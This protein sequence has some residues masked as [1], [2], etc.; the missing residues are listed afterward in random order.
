VP[1][2]EPKKSKSAAKQVS[3]RGG[4]PSHP[5][6]PKARRRP[7]TGPGAAVTAQTT[8]SAGASTTDELPVEPDAPES[9]VPDVLVGTAPVVPTPGIVAGGIRSGLSIRSVLMIMLI[10]VSIASSVV[11]GAIGYVN[12]RASLNDAAF[13]RLTE[14]RD[15][16]AREV[17]ALFDSVKSSLMINSRGQSVTAATTAFSAAFADLETA[18]LTAAEN[19]TVDGYYSSTFAPALAK[20]TGETVDASSFDPTDPAA[21]YLTLNYVAQ[22]TDAAAALANNDAGDGSAWSEAHAKYHDY[23]RTMTQLLGY[24]DVLLVD[25]RGNVVYT[26]Q[27]N[28]DLGTNLVTGPY[29]F[30]NL[31]KAFGSAIT[32]NITDSVTFTDYEPYSPALGKPVAWAVSPVAI[33]GRVVG[34]IAVELP[35]K[36]IDA[37][38]TGGDDW[39]RGALG[40][41]GETYLV[42]P[43]RLMRTPSRDLIEDPKRYQ[44]EAIAAGLS[45]RATSKAIAAGT[46]LVQSV[47]TKA[48]DNALA[49]ETGTVVAPGY[50]GGETLAASAPL[51]IEDL[52]W[53]IV[54]EIDSAEAFA[55]VDTFARTLLIS[56]A[57]IV[58]IVIILSLLLPGFIV[59]PLRRLKAA[60]RSIAAGDVGVQV[61]AGNSDE[62]AELGGAFNDM[63][64]SLQLKATLL[65][66]QQEENNRLLGFLMP[67]SVAKRYRDGDKTISEDHK[68]VSVIYADIVGFDEFSR[69]LPSEKGLELLNDLVRRFDEAA[70][71]HGVERVRTTRQGYLASCGLTVPRVDNARRAV[72]FAIEL[73]TILTR[74]GAQHGVELN[75]R[76]GID[77]GTVT[78]GLVGRSYVAYDLWGDAVNLAFH[79]QSGTSGAGIYIS[80]QVFDHLADSRPL[81]DAGTIM[82]DSGKVRVWKVDTEAA[83]V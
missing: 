82:S 26:A 74:F 81:I 80:E 42:G 1:K 73:Q 24:G 77:T 52:D 49:G 41:T 25:A 83:G 13:A 11:I 12:G 65:E 36:K 56:T 57:V 6:G 15:S 2:K 67:E 37:V 68:E 50:L 75:L 29:R 59:R 64:K 16:R 9:T 79:L 18:K 71:E 76:A 33:D 27:K 31:A 70:E 28:V 62:L 72:D 10:S 43:D 21:R 61:D 23:F 7:T 51:G 54:A 53:V 48:V 55:P 60:A 20:A 47:R 78:A 8:A 5:G 14:V 32:K 4:E 40:A 17:T 19:S 66:Q 30:S 38:M 69:T 39:S 3:A 34:T 44:R 58:F 63:S 35:T 46:L 22:N 45:V